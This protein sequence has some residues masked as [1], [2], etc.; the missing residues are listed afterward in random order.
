[1]E[2]LYCL[3]NKYINVDVLSWILD[4]GLICDCYVVG[5]FFESFLCGGCGYCVRVYN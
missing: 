1:M 3:G 4:D 5:V 2:I